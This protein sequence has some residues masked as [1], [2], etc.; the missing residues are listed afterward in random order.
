[1]TVNQT[2]KKQFFRLKNDLKYFVI[3]LIFF[4]VANV[5]AKSA[6]VALESLISKT[7]GMAAESVV[8]SRE[9][10]INAAIE[11][12][13][14]KNKSI[15]V[16]DINSKNFNN[17]LTQNLIEIVVYSEAVLFDVSQL[18][19]DEYKLAIQDVSKVLQTNPAWKSLKV[20]NAE[21]ESF[22]KR[23]LL[24]KKFIKIKSD[25]MKG[26][27][28]DQ[29]A[30]EYYEKNRIKFGQLPFVEFKENIKSFLTQQQ[31]EER[32]KSWFEIIK[33]K[34]KVKNYLNDNGLS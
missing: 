30:K 29:E 8:T 7:V 22:L 31:L 12:A 25:S 27:I 21:L 18:A 15:S 4:Q 10:I 14:S 11:Q 3:V 28:T 2:A 16:I 23:K 34:Y 13:L 1:M 32:L 20:T 19:E 5:L 9:V 24:A 17:E 26:F 33:K 6:E